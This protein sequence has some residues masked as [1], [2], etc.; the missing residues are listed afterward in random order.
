MDDEWKASFDEIKSKYELAFQTIEVGEKYEAAANA[1]LAIVNYKIGI[2]FIDKA[3]ATPVALP[4]DTDSLDDSWSVAL[5]M[6]QKLKR[7][8]G[9]LLRRIV[10]LTP[11]S[12]V[13]VKSDATKSVNESEQTEPKLRPRTFMELA[14]ALQ[15]FE[16]ESNELPSILEILLL[17]ENVKLYRIKASGEVTT[18]D[19][20]STLRIIRLD[21][22][23]TRNVE[24]T[25][26]MQIIRSSAAQQIEEKMEEDSGNDDVE[27]QIDDSNRK[28][29]P[30]EN[31]P[32]NDASIFYPLIPSVTP[33]IR[34]EFGAFI[35]PDLESDEEG[36]A[37]GLVIPSALEEL[38]LE[39]FDAVLHGIIRQGEAEEEPEEEEGEESEAKRARR[40]RSDAISENIVKGACF[41]SNGLVK[42]SEQLGRFVTFSTPYLLS[43]LSRA[44]ENG[45]PVSDKV[46]NS[47]EIAKTATGLAA[48]ATGFVAGKVGAATIA[49][50]RFLAPHVHAQGTRLLTHTIGVNQDEAEGRVRPN[51]SNLIV[52]YK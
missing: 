13:S 8:R 20:S 5:Q 2:E 28:S 49:L 26:F 31:E 11:S 29:P 40:T 32:K 50:G 3:L 12:S 15:N 42:G 19:E 18:T 39:I 37:F 1:E 27:N 33:I 43:K 6:I 14:E 25:Y 38:V 24:A 16:I 44:P 36:A 30:K 4:D 7:T 48:S 51:W 9:E 21:Q 22:D 23:L 17:C 46:R 35:F 47:V 41:V 10:L 45:P 52:K 34:T